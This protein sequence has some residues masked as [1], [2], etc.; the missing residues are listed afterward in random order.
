MS[1]YKLDQTGGD[2]DVIMH[3]TQAYANLTEAEKKLVF[4]NQ[5]AALIIHKNMER[6]F[7]A[8]ARNF[9]GV[10]AVN[11]QADAFRHAYF[12]ALNARA[13]GYD[14]A[15]Q[16]G[17]AHEQTTFIDPLASQMDISNNI[18]GYN[19]TVYYP[20]AS[21]RQLESLILNSITNGSLVMISN[22]RIVPTQ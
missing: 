20:N 1:D 2:G 9:P 5:G 6:S 8:T 19:L 17:I 3:E 22:G 12:S 11:N 14:L 13:V 16:F 18:Y 21:T 15:F 7:A 10:R 4:S